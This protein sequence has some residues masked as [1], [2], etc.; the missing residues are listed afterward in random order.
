MAVVRCVNRLNTLLLKGVKSQNTF[1]FGKSGTPVLTAYEP[2]KQSASEC[3]EQGPCGRAKKGVSVGG[4]RTDRSIVV[5]FRK[6]A[7]SGFAVVWTGHDVSGQRLVGDA[8]LAGEISKRAGAD[9]DCSQAT[10]DGARRVSRAH[11]ANAVLSGEVVG[12]QRQTGAR[13]CVHA[14]QSQRCFSHFPFTLRRYCKSL[15]AGSGPRSTGVFQPFH[16]AIQTQPHVLGGGGYCPD[17]APARAQIHCQHHRISGDHPAESRTGSTS[18]S[19]DARYRKIAGQLTKALGP[20]LQSGSRKP[21]NRLAFRLVKTACCQ[22]V[23]CQEN[24]PK[25]QKLLY[26]TFNLIL[27]I[28]GMKMTALAMGFGAALAAGPQDANA[29]AT[30]IMIPLDSGAEIVINLSGISAQVQ[31]DVMATLQGCIEAGTASRDECVAGFAK[32]IAE[33]RLDA[34][35]LNTHQQLVPLENDIGLTAAEIIQEPAFCA[36]APSP[37]AADGCT[38]S[39]GAVQLA[40]A[41]YQL[42]SAREALIVAETREAEI[43]QATVVAET[44][45]AGIDTAISTQTE[46]AETAEASAEAYAAVLAALQRVA[47]ENQTN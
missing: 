18:P 3:V 19:N 4:D 10:K 30:K 35:V 13:F 36:Y 15:G 2:A 33:M 24:L 28:M 16:S 1:A 37:K 12:G 7:R 34:I 22:I 31:G 8:S 38:S 6:L 23:F 11:L 27:L 14:G 43:D 17:L 25:L 29:Q 39:I 26:N 5:G 42:A 47:A 41:V 21:L 44:R 9:V 32:D 46:R 20:F 40:A 45:E